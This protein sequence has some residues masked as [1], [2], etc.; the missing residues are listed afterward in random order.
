VLKRW[1]EHREDHV[2]VVNV[3][4]FRGDNLVDNMISFPCRAT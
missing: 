2:E 1:H 4:G 3:L